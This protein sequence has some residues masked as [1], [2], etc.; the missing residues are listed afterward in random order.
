MRKLLIFVVESKSGKENSD[1]VYINVTLR[2]F[3]DYGNDTIIRYVYMNG[4]GNFDKRSTLNQINKYILDS[5]KIDPKT[6]IYVYYVFDKDKI[7]NSNED[8]SFVKNVEVF[9]K[10]NDYHV[11]WMNRTIEEVFLNEIVE[12]HQKV[13]MASRFQSRNM[14]EKVNPK[15]LSTVN[16][17]N[18]NTSNILNLLDQVLK[19]KK[20]IEF[21]CIN[22]IRYTSYNEKSRRY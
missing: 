22:R 3:Y 4:K 2:N 13:K 9:C 18:Q 16:A 21:T 11:I 19:R 20:W 17:D 14:I 7:Y 12:R 15:Q 6:H 1:G 5:R 10:T 8:V